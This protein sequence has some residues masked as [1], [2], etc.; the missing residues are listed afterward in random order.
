MVEYVIMTV[1]IRTIATKRAAMI[2]NC[3]LLFVL[4]SSHLPQLKD[5][6]S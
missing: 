3:P 2:E 1:P 6:E 5:Y 4:H